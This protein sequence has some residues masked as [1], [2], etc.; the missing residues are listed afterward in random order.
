MIVKTT[1][2]SNTHTLL[3]SKN[4]DSSPTLVHTL[5]RSGVALWEQNAGYANPAGL[6][7]S[8]CGVIQIESVRITLCFFPDFV[9][10]AI[11]LL[12]IVHTRSDHLAWTLVL[13]DSWIIMQELITLGLHPSVEAPSFT[14]AGQHATAEEFH[15]LLQEASAREQSSTSEEGETGVKSG[16][17]KKCVLIDARNI[18]ETRI[19]K[20]HPP[21]EV[22]CY[23]PLVRQYSDLPAWLDAH[24]EQLRNKRV[25][26]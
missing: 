25:L 20:F 22:E 15:S 23:D 21:S 5:T 4:G 26:M 2:S 17:M 8:P 14:N 10:R 24:Q 9:D 13:I 11:S 19:G 7:F 18:Y 16:A 1:I 3:V 12:D 6:I